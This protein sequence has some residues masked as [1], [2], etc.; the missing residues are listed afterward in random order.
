[1]RIIRTSASEHS[2]REQFETNLNNI[3]EYATY[4][5][6][7]GVTEEQLEGWTMDKISTVKDDLG[8]VKHFYSDSEVDIDNP[9]KDVPTSELRKK[10]LWLEHDNQYIEQREGIDSG[11]D[12]ESYEKN[13]SLM[14]DELDRR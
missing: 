13:M 3:I 2:M 7:R 14:R 10:L 1:M 11:V 9:F 5:K 6:Q 8:D 4:L 12:M